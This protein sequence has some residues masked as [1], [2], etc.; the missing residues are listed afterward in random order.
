MSCAKT[1]E[2]IKLTFGMRIW[3][4]HVIRWGPD[5][6]RGNFHGESG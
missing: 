2:T 4:G 3:V 5:P 1:A 6:K